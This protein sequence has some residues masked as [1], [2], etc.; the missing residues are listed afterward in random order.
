[1]SPPDTTV[2][3]AST[4]TVLASTVPT[5]NAPS[6]S[7]PTSLLPIAEVEPAARLDPVVVAG[8][9]ADGF[10][11][12]L[13]A[14]HAV[15]VDPSAAPADRARAGVDHQLVLRELAD[16][17]DLDEAVLE[18]LAAPARASIERVVR[19]R[20][21]L[22][23]RSAARPAQPLPDVLPAWTIV[24][25][26]SVDSLRSYYDEAEQLTGIAWYWLAAIN[27]QETRMG[28]IRGVS[29]AGA[30]GPM[31]FLPSTWEVCCTGDPT[32]TRDAIIGAATYLAQSGG[33]DDMAAAVYQYNPNDGYVAVVTAYA[34]S[35]RDEPELYSGYHA[36]QVF[37]GTSAGTVRLPVGY[38]E[39]API[40][41]VTYLAEHPSDA[42]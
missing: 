36:F 3:V 30:V 9:D 17:P 16:R 8:L 18:L 13:S 2:A 28:R 5:S 7:V 39:P 41:A 20:Q 25:P 1:M 29:S 24:E 38:A 37:Y 27:L 23:A 15:M 40:D 26:E 6:S 42:A 32:A 19:A 34:E 14:S 35:L 21:F 31:Q 22:Q 10:A 11:A 33:P 4:S 12:L